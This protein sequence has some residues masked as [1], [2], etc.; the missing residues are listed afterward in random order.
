MKIHLGEN[1][2]CSAS[3]KTTLVNQK[4]DILSTQPPTHSLIII[5]PGTNLEKVPTETISIA[6]YDAQLSLNTSP[7]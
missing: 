4:I 7:Y 1:V 2:L 3:L 5:F 6:I